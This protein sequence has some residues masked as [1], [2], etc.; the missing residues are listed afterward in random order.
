MSASTVITEGF[1]TFGSN[2][3]VVTQG[4][5][6][7]G[8]AVPPAAAAETGRWAKKKKKREPI[9]FSDFE[10][11]EAVANAMAAELALKAIAIEE[12]TDD[13]EFEDDEALIKALTI[14][15]IH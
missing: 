1:G 6:D 5:G 4:F 11:R 14:T 2:N 7:Y 15:I 10:S 8:G 13:T 12:L 9:R 3:F